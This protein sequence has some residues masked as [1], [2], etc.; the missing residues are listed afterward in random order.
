MK[1]RLI[2]IF[3]ITFVICFCFTGCFSNKLSVD[4]TV[5]VQ[6]MGVD[7][8]IKKDEYIVSI[9][10]FDIAKAGAKGQ[11]QSGTLTKVI[12]VRGKSIKQAIEKSTQITGKSLVDSQNR[13]I[14]FGEEVLRFGLDSV[15]DSF[16][17]DYKV[18]ANIPIAVAKGIKAEKIIM[19]DQGKVPI[20]AKTIQL[21]LESGGINAY[22]PDITLADVIRHKE[23][24][25]T[26]IIMPALTIREENK[27]QYAKLDGMAVFK[28]KELYDY[29]TIDETRSFNW[30]MD[31]VKSGTI[32]V[33]K[34]PK[35]VITFDIV[36]SNT[37]TETQIK[38]DGSLQYNIDIKCSLDVTE[39]DFEDQNNL[40][41]NDILEI[42]KLA[43]TKIK[44]DVLEV[45]NK[46]LV[47]YKCDPFRFGK[48]FMLKSP[49][50]YR[51]LS[52]DWDKVIPG[53]KTNVSVDVTLRRL[54][55]FTVAE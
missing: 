44:K 37:K 14:I 1:T 30:I 55:R 42:E 10:C 40:S 2:S 50:D 49:D 35:E 13:V 41:K 5:L 39:I 34:P 26:S 27:H 16:A 32:V 47:D 51:K 12:K 36:K 22:S 6:A 31:K 52:G 53:I 3:F 15:L 9:Q 24:K 4:K 17:R 48:R 18:R 19:A 11:A 43:Q 54:G 46:C 8:D 33:K 21:I 28:G 7:Y 29:L 45:L 23:E 38:D 25:T 20:P